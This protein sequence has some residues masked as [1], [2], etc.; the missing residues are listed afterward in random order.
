MP[1][2]FFNAL[3]IVF[4]NIFFSLFFVIQQHDTFQ[5]GIRE[6]QFTYFFHHHLANVDQEFI[7]AVSHKSS[8]DFF[9]NLSAEFFFSLHNTFAECLVEYFLCQFTRNKTSDFFYLEAEIRLHVF[10]NFLVNLQQRTQFSSMSVISHIRIEHQYI[11]YFCISKNSFLIVVLHVS[12]HQYCSFYLDTTF[13]CVAFFVQLCQQ[14]FQH[15]IIFVSVYLII[16]ASALSIHL[17]LVVDHFVRN[18]DSIIIYFIFS[19]YFCFKFRCQSNVEYEIE[20]FHCIEINILLLFFVRQRLAQH[21]HLIFFNI[22]VNSFLQ[23]LIHNL[24]NYRLTIHLFNKTC[25]NHTFTESR[26]LCL[27]TE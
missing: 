14:T 2:Q 16:L 21:I 3:I 20:F 24:C 25:R 19:T 11:I 13:F 10:C 26:N 22:I 9:F 18:F 5:Q 7:I 17:H 27:L 15:I 1:S 6:F 4:S 12:R 8:C 23:C